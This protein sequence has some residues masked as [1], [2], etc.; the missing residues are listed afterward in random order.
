MLSDWNGPWHQTNKKK[1]E[2]GDRGLEVRL[3]AKERKRKADRRSFLY[4]LPFL[5]FFRL[6][7]SQSLFIP[8][9]LFVVVGKFLSFLRS[10]ICPRIRCIDQYITVY[11][12]P[13]SR[14]QHGHQSPPPAA[15]VLPL[16]PLPPPLDDRGQV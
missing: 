16:R 5:L 13:H 3:A 6:I 9:Y 14:L 12:F 10:G 2:G 15:L 1:G 7:Q 11:Y 8:R 4:L